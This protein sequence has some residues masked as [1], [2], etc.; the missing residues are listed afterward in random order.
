MIGP[1]LFFPCLKKKGLAYG[2]FGGRFRP[3]AS[4]SS[5]QWFISTISSRVKEYSLEERCSGSFLN[6]ILILKSGQEWGSS[7]HFASLKTE[8]WRLGQ[9]GVGPVLGK[10]VSRILA[11]A[12][13]LVFRGVAAHAG[14]RRL[15]GEE[16]QVLGQWESLTS[17]F[18]QLISGLC[19]FSQSCPRITMWGWVFPSRKWIHSWWSPI[20]TSKSIPYLILP[21]LFCVPSTLYIVI[22]FGRGDGSSPTFFAHSK[23]IKQLGAA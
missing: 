16:E 5:T 12:R 1:S 3:K 9:L 10:W 21:F 4:C 22:G 23:S 18:A 20:I 8:G 13:V 15:G 2:V 17:A 14:V 7:S 11:V 6:S 19:H